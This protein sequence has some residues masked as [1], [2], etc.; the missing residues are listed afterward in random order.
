MFENSNENISNWIQKI[1]IDPIFE[2]EGIYIWIL[3]FKEET[4]E[5]CTSMNVLLAL[6]IS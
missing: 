1:K 6:G 4:D 3:D 2:A 5:M